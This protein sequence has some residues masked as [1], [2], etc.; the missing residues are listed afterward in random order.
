[1]WSDM[2]EQDDSTYSFESAGGDV[3]LEK[4]ASQSNG[5]F[6]EPIFGMTPAQRLVVALFLLVD[7]CILGVLFLVVFQKVYL[8]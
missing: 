7:V 6:T 4:P 5:L 3:G 2:P 1:M 8:L